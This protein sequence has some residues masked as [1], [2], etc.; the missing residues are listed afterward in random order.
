[1]HAKSRST[2]LSAGPRPRAALGIA[3]ALGLV[4][5]Q[6]GAQTTPAQVVRGPVATYWLSADTVSG[7]G[8]MGA[9]GGMGI[10]GMLGML[11]GR[12][13][14]PVRTLD[15]KLG[16]SQ[17]ASGAPEAAHLI[18]AGMS[19]GPQLPL[20][21]PEPTRAST[22]PAERT[23]PKGIDEQPKG[24]ML[25]YW[26][27]GEK[28][29]A[30]QPVV[31]DFSKI[32]PGQPMPNL[33]S[34]SVRGP[35]GPSFG[36]SRSYGAWPNE[37]DRQTVPAQASLRG[38]HQ[39]K[40]NYSP[41]IRFAVEQHDFMPPVEL[42]TSRQPTGTQQLSWRPVGGATGYFMSAVGAGGADGGSTVDIVMWTSSAVQETGGALADYVQPAEVARLIRERVVL[43]PD[44]TECTL[45]A[46]VVKAMP[47]GLLSFIAYGDE[48]NVS[49]PPRPADP[50]VPWD[51][52]WSVKLRLKSSTSQMLG[53]GM[54]G[55]GG[56][57][58]GGGNSPAATPAAGSA[59]PGAAPQSESARPPASQAPANQTDAVEQGL[60][61][62]ARVLRGLFNR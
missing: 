10:G 35:R 46:E 26:G 58:G 53:E 54:A 55:L 2:L 8:A 41:D 3:A 24:R 47:A 21:T 6:A 19:M 28:V 11:A 60:R 56:T 52:Q 33:A 27:C 40:G 44:R 36:Q 31:I 38:E 45:P 37:R 1:M 48:L 15:L 20:V 5:P 62:G 51:I 12:A 23:L 9:G 25:I 49:H 18:P 14:A 13:P 22:E 39:V 34:R 32:G 61:E 16:S 17:G 42:S 50:K 57:G 29:G 59:P 4:A 7:F 30:G 43:P